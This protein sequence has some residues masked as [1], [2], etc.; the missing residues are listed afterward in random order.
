MAQTVYLDKCPPAPL[1]FNKCPPA[2]VLFNKCPPAPLLFNKCPPA[3]L[4]FNKCPPALSCSFSRS[5]FC[6][7]LHGVGVQPAAFSLAPR[8]VLFTG[9]LGPHTIQD[10]RQKVRD[11]HS[12]THG[13][14]DP[15]S[16]PTRV[17]AVKGVRLAWRNEMCARWARCGRDVRVM[18]EMWARCG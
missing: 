2:P 1:L 16:I 10:K 8:V 4:L 5:A 17:I 15:N 9:H 6:R 12:I 14:K 7:N 3:P 18:G 13:V 11:P